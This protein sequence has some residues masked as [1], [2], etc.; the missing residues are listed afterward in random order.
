M[1]GMRQGGKSNVGFVFPQKRDRFG[2]SLSAS[3]QCIREGTH[4]ADEPSFMFYGG[5]FIQKRGQKGT[6]FPKMTIF[7]PFSVYGNSQSSSGNGCPFVS[8]PIQAKRIPRI[9]V[10][11]IVAPA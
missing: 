5:S 7:Y 6:F 8:G 4:L 1:G 9:K 2:K 10:T 3:L 11:A